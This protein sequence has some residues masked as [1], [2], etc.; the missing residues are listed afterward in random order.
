MLLFHF[1]PFVFFMWL[2]VAANR[3]SILFPI[4]L[5]SP[6]TVVFFLVLR[7]LIVSQERF[8]QQYKSHIQY[9]PLQ[10]TVA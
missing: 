1:I 2:G 3:A 8:E 7:F 5:Q 4:A 6:N 10:V 9:V